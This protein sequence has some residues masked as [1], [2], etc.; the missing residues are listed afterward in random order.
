MRHA[1]ETILAFDP[2][3][4]CSG[5]AIFQEGRLEWVG[6]AK[7]YQNDMPRDIEGANLMASCILDCLSN[8]QLDLI[9]RNRLVYEK[10][11]VYDFGGDVD[12]DDVMQLAYVNGAVGRTLNPKNMTGLFAREWKGQVPKDVSHRQAIGKL[13]ADETRLVNKAE[14]THQS[15][16]MHNLKDAVAIGLSYYRRILL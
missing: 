5:M 11:Q 3:L 12:P 10:P 6:M 7:P 14:E 16:L 2:G 4:R 9:S 13:D 15:S 1:N 8:E